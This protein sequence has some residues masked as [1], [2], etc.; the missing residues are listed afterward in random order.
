MNFSRSRLAALV[1]ALAYAATAAVLARSA[2]A[3]VWTGAIALVPV[4]LIWFPDFWGAAGGRITSETPASVVEVAGWAVL[5]GGP[6]ALL[7]LYLLGAIKF[8]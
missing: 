5:V 3:G 2:W 1:I 8:A 6:V 7:V 4:S